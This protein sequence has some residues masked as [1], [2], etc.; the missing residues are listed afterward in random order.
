V[1]KNYTSVL[2]LL[3]RLRQACNHPILVSKDFAIDAEAIESS[4]ATKD[5]DA[6]LAD[7]LAGLTVTARGTCQVCMVELTPANHNINSTRCT[8]CD[9]AVAVENRRKSVGRSGATMN[10]SSAKIRKTIDL[11]DQVLGKEVPEGEMPEKVIIFSQFTSF[12]DLL[13]PFLLEERIKFVRV[14]G[15]MLPQ[16]RAV[17]VEKIKRSRSTRVIL[18]SFKAGSTGLNLTCCNHVILTDLWWNPA[19][20]DQAFDRAHRMGQTRDVEIYK[21]TVPDTVEQRILGLQDDKRNLAAAALSGDKFKTGNKLRLEDIVQ[22]FK[23]GDH[24]DS[25]DGDDD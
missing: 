15:S 2:T 20:E 16:D 21:L 25:D 13:E 6:G 5:D 7:A 17:A 8:S 9:V 11:L 22:L 14:D 24:N 18:I 3:L 12:L 4:P 19:L 1:M 23:G 10:Q